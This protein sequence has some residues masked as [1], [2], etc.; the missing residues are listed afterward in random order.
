MTRHLSQPW[1]IDH[2]EIVAI[3]LD[4]M[5]APA[6]RMHYSALVL[7]LADAAIER[8]RCELT[9]TPTPQAPGSSPTAVPASL[10]LGTCEVEGLWVG[11]NT[12]SDQTLPGI[13]LPCHMSGNEI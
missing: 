10:P 3:A 13:R 2:P 1:P 7:A 4:L 9:A 5:L 6:R 11:L 12:E 8:L